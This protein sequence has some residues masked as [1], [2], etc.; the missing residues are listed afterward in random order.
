[1]EEQTG[2]PKSQTISRPPSSTSFRGRDATGLS[3][4]SK[5]DCLTRQS[6]IRFACQQVELE[7]TML[8]VQSTA[9]TCTSR[10][11]ARLVRSP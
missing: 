5:S 2:Q 8:S 11:H 4:A 10:S 7:N 3:R 6:V 1:M 9:V